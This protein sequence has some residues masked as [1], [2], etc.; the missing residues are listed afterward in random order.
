MGSATRARLPEPLQS[1]H[2]PFLVRGL[3]AILALLRAM[4]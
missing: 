3:P 4:R 1:G 2:E